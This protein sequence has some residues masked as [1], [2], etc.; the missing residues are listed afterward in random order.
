MKKRTVFLTGA[1]AGMAA[2][3][4]QADAEAFPD[5]SEDMR[6][7]LAID[8]LYKEGIINGFDDGTFRPNA[9]L[10]RI[11]AVLMLE[12]ALNLEFDGEVSHDFDDVPEAYNEVVDML[13]EEGI[14]EGYSLDEFGTYV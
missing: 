11:E 8:T 5:I 14:F 2:M 10:T 13:Y 6:H 7:Y 9:S 12:R 1:L 3:S 4:V